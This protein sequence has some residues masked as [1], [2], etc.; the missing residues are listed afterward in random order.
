M[1][2]SF[3]CDTSGSNPREVAGPGEASPGGVDWYKDCSLKPEETIVFQDETGFSLHSHLRR[4]WA[5]KGQKLRVPT[6]SQH[7]ERLNM[8]GWVVPL[9]GKKGLIR[10]EQ[11]NREGFLKVLGRTFCK[12]CRATISGFMLTGLPGTEG[13]KLSSPSRIIP[14]FI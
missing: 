7:R 4:G 12:G 3:K 13:R 2:E 1:H 10:T 9:L 6:T 11:G 5:K 8:S 14:S